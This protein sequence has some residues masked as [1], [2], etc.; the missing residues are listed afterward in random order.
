[1]HKQTRKSIIRSLHRYRVPSRLTEK[2]VSS[3]LESINTPRSLTV[4]LLFKYG[5]HRQLVDLTIN[6]LDYESSREG[7]LKFRDDYLATELLSKSDFLKLDSDKAAVA[8]EKFF[9]AEDRNRRTN[10][11]WSFL[12]HHKL[13]GDRAWLL[14]A[15]TRKIG[16]ILGDFDPEEWFEQCSWGPG[17][18]F[19]SGGLDT[20]SVNKFQ[21]ESGITLDLYQLVKDLIPMYFPLWGEHLSGRY[22]FTPGNKVTTVPKNAKTDRVIAIEPGLNVFF[23]LGLGRMISRR[24]LR[25]EGIDLR[26]QERNGM[27]AYYASLS[28]KLATVDFSSASDLISTEVVREILPPRW[29]LVL[30]ACRSK[31]SKVGDKFL[32]MEKFSSMGNGFTFPL[33][34]LI[35]FACAHAA[36]EFCGVASDY[37]GVFGDDVVIP[38]EAYAT[39]Q[40]LCDYLGFSINPEKSFDSGCFRESCGTH[41]FWGYDV[42]PLYIK[43]GLSDVESVFKLANGLR[44]LAHRRNLNYGCDAT[45]RRPWLYLYGAVPKELRFCIPE[46]YGDGGFVDNFDSSAPPA[47]RPK[48]HNL[49]LWIE[50]FKVWVV[51]HTAIKRASE[52][53]G[54]LLSRLFYPSV[55]EFGNSYPLRSATRRKIALLHVHSWYDLGPWF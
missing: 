17:A 27:L 24:L 15:V 47:Y 16:Q 23:Q 36:C 3:I 42:K 21:N 12:D 48:R 44:R 7:S 46:G 50:G 32:R 8:M 45:L 38:V 2:A 39:F 41:Y 5:E 55:E 30:D 6:P 52:N 13:S 18:T 11:F 25:A 22:C 1:M 33:Q 26:T 43:K 49:G 19:N 31:L 29:F 53:L 51:S 4:A 40:E 28:G 34:S 20:S 35:F 9:T 37:V 54:L 10:S 14:N